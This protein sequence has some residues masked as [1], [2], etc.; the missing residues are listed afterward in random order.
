MLQGLLQLDVLCC[1]LTAL[2]L[3]SVH[4][5]HRRSQATLPWSCAYPPGVAWGWSGERCTYGWLA[6]DTRACVLLAPMCEQMTCEAKSC[7]GAAESS[8]WERLSSTTWAHCSPSVH[9]TEHPQ[10]RGTCLGAAKSC[11][12][13]IILAVCGVH[14]MP[15]HR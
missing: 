3:L 7:C 10:C 11:M 13:S 9:R 4:Q 1:M 5:P 8:R 14:S 2:L 12:T 15:F 6:Q